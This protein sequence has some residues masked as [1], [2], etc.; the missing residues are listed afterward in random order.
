MHTA[1]AVYQTF[2]VSATIFIC[3]KVHVCSLWLYTIRHLKLK[4]INYLKVCE[5]RNQ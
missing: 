1:C 3:T 2:G 5:S 4:K